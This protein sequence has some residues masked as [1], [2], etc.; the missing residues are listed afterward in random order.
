MRPS[1]DHDYENTQKVDEHHPRPQEAG[2]LLCC[3][4]STRLDDGSHS[5]AES[6]MIQHQHA[7]RTLHMQPYQGPGPIVSITVVNPCHSD[8]ILPTIEEVTGSLLV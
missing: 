7:M 8:S 6:E 5:V 1:L 4:N 2:T 3:I